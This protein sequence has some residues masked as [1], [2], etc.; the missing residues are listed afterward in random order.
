MKLGHD[1][2]VYLDQ[3]LDLIIIEVHYTYWPLQR[4]RS[5][6]RVLTATFSFSVKPSDR[7]DVVSSNKREQREQEMDSDLSTKYTDSQLFTQVN[8]EY[9]KKEQGDALLSDR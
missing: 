5:M 4:K 7:F 6:V 9:H 1:D 8:E 3:N 2:K